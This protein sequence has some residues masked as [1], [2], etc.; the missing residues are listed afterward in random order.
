[1]RCSIKLNVFGK[2]VLATRGNEDW[3][4]YY[5]SEDGKRRT[6][7]EDLFVPDFVTESELEEYL[8]DL[9]HEW[10]TE[11]HPNVRRLN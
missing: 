8:E 10:V 9:C 7:A 11:K 3:H 1:M 6:A 5:L 4:L 2:F